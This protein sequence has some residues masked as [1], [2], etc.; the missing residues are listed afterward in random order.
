MIIIDNLDKI[1]QIQ[2]AFNILY[3]IN[4][5]DFYLFQLIFIEDLKANLLIKKAVGEL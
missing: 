3:M 1:N 2:N 4:F 5:L